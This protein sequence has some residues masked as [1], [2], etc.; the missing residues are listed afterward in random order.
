MNADN[1][2]S[3]S[4]EVNQQNL[5]VVEIALGVPSDE[6]LARLADAWDSFYERLAQ[7]ESEAVNG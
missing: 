4:L 2:N 6:E 3:P 7:R 1:S 5:R